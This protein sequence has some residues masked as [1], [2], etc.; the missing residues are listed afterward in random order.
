MHGLAVDGFG[1]AFLEKA[2]K[3]GESL[4]HLVEAFRWT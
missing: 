3:L 4:R 1:G 2:L